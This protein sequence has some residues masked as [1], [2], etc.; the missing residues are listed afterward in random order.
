MRK[1]IGLLERLVRII[2]GIA[3]LSL[4]FTGPQSAW[5]YLGII[6]L[7][8][9]IAGWCPLYTLLGLSTCRNCS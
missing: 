8:T 2:A 4:A 7:L 5:A 9:G 6:P 1:N 3:V